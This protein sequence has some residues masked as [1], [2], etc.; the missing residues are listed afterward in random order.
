MY[1]G[2]LFELIT[3]NPPVQQIHPNKTEEN[4]SLQNIGMEI[5][6]S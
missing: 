5:A 4:N 6:I 3:M 1:N 2:S